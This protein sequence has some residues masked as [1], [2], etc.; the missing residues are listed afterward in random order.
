MKT[1]FLKITSSASLVVIPTVLELPIIT[2]PQQT[3]HST[4]TPPLLEIDFKD[5]FVEELVDSFYKSLR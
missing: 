2:M 3:F 5:E 1:L 4:T